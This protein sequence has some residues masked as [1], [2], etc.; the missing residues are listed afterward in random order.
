MKKLKMNSSLISV[1]KKS[2]NKFKAYSTLHSYSKSEFV[3]QAGS[4]KTNF[5]LLLSGRVKLYRV[6]SLG[7]EVTQWF[8]F[9]GEAF[10][11]SELQSTQ[12]QSIYAQCCEQSDVLSIP[13][14]QF[15]RF[16][17]QSPDIALKIIEQLSVRLKITG[18]TLL[19]FTSDDIKTRLIKLIIRLNMRFGIEYRKGSLINIELTHQEIADMIGAC[20][21][22]VTAVLGELKES[23]NIEIID[24]HFFIPSLHAFEQLAGTKY[25]E[26]Q[27]KKQPTEFLIHG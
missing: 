20:R 15:N 3:F 26:R 18:E 17:K 8:C 12:H 10:G 13:L 25:H 27:Y 21:Q 23:G 4:V 16:I 22:S 1:D 24:H 11:L 6:S 9:P 5:F 2:L 19:N 7:R 14:K